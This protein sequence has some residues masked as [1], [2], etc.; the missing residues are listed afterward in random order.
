MKEI[1][2]KNIFA[3][4]FRII[5]R[6]FSVRVSLRPVCVQSASSQRGVALIITILL[7]S[8]MLTSVGIF[9]KEMAEEARN[10]ARLDNSLIAYYAAE[11][12][13]EDALLAWRYDKDAEISADDDNTPSVDVTEKTIGTPR[14]VS[15]ETNETLTD[16]GICSSLT[17]NFANF[18]NRHYALR[19]WY[20]TNEIKDYKLNRDD[21][22]EIEVPNLTGE[23]DLRWS[24]GGGSI[25]LFGPGKSGYSMEIT[26]YDENGEI[27]DKGKSFTIPGETSPPPKSTL[28]ISNLGTGRKIVRIKP[29]Y[30]KVVSNP[31]DPRSEGCSVLNANTDPQ[32][33]GTTYSGTP[34]VLINASS[35]TDLMT[36]P[37]THIESVGYYGGVARKISVDL[38][39]T[40]GKI[41]GMLDYAIY[42]EAD[43]VK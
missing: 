38:D 11:A 33:A 36:T 13:L 26:A 7:S 37:V 35:D 34:S 28:S 43:L 12:G 31:T 8:I 20:K 25:P 22:L 29:W 42:S 4:S 27:I 32:C 2:T 1:K 16:P 5:L 21:V 15:L 3:S 18:N 19:M 17:A 40:T 10:S 23:L 39:R 6:A 30:T 9:A 14:C 24:N 41:I